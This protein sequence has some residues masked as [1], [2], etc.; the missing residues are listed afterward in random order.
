MLVKHN[1]IKN[2]IVKKTYRFYC[3]GA[4]IARKLNK[5]VHTQL[6]SKTRSSFQKKKEVALSSGVEA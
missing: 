1:F 2:I 6:R 5:Q 3:D 4:L